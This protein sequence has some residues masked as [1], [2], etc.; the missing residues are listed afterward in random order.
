MKVVFARLAE[1]RSDVVRE[2]FAD[3]DS[4]RGREQYRRRDRKNFYKQNIC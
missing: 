4:H 1:Q 3:N 2:H